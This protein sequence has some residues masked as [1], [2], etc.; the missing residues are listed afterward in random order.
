MGR[1]FGLILML[2]ALYVGLQIWTQGAERAFGLASDASEAGEAPTAPLSSHLTPLAQ[3]ADV[4]PTPIRKRRVPLTQAIKERADSH[5][6]KG[7]K[8]S[9][10][11][12]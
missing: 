2:L 3:S 10:A 11:D 5:I 7:E 9:E 6:R 12:R 4:P 8:A 1:G